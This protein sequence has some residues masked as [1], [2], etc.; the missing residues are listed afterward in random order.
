MINIIIAM[1]MYIRKFSRLK[2]KVIIWGKGGEVGLGSYI[3]MYY[4]CYTC[5][6]EVERSWKIA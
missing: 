5:M 1:Y 3:Y 4:Q 6:L 2:K